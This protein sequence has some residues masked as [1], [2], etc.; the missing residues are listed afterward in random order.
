ML[1]ADYY[2][3]SEKPRYLGDPA[4]PL[5]FDPY[6]YRLEQKDRAARIKQIHEQGTQAVADALSRLAF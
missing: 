5:E 4:L 2:E 1:R 3:R 6:L